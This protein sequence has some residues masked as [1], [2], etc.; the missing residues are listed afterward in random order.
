VVVPNRVRFLLLF[1]QGP[2]FPVSSHK[3]PRLAQFHSLR[4]FSIS[5]CHKSPAVF[6]QS[7]FLGKK[8][9]CPLPPLETAILSICPTFSFGGKRLGSIPPVFFF[10]TE[11]LR[12]PFPPPWKPNPWKTMH[13]RLG[14]STY[15]FSPPFLFQP[16]PRDNAFSLFLCVPPLLP[17]KD[18]EKIFPLSF[19]ENPPLST[20]K[21]TF[22]LEVFF[23]FISLRFPVLVLVPGWEV[24]FG[25]STLA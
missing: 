1:P 16:S 14:S 9:A 18:S 5:S 3:E 24:F 15:V 4:S 2:N 13:Q 7:S 6:F 12:C 17:S 21:L 22:D 19:L 8:G 23:F 10:K 11:F 20:T 25:K